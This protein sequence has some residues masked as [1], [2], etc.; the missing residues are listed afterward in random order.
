[1]SVM[2]FQLSSRNCV[3][4]YQPKQ[5]CILITFMK[6]LGYR[7]NIKH[8]NSDYLSAKEC[9]SDQ[10]AR[11]VVVIPTFARNSTIPAGSIIVTSHV[12]ANSLQ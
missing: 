6:I 2:F 4:L 8:G 9:Y 5:V 10:L 7:K 3:T 1:M 11:S 12:Q